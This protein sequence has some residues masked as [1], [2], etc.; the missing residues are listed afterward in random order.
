M[1]KNMLP[2]QQRDIWERCF[3]PTGTFVE[4]ERAAIEQSIQER[5]EQQVLAFPDN[6]AVWTDNEELTYSQL[7]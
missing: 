4:F 2:A 5:F 7:N 1:A 3:H 6:P